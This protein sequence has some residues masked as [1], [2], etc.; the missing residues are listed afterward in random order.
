MLTAISNVNLNQKYS[1]KPSFG[2]VVLSRV[3]LRTV[4]KNGDIFYTPILNNEKGIKG[5]YQALSRRVNSAKN[6]TLLTKLSDAIADFK[7]NKPIIYSTIINVRSS[8]K[9]FL[10][11]GSDAKMA[12]DMG[13]DLIGA[14][15]NRRAYANTIK[16]EILNKPKKR[17]FNPDGDEIG[18]DLIVEGPKGKR[19]LVDIE[20][21]TLQ[22][23]SKAKPPK[24]A[25]NKK[26]IAKLNE[27]NIK[28]QNTSQPS[29]T[30]DEIQ[31]EFDFVSEL[32][33]KKI[34]PRDYD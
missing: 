17:V 28:P 34:N 8:F 15:N 11:T 23:I 16:E 10:L 1:Y 22:E 26:E 31:R 14:M 18:I 19:K 25:S 12:R 29:T 33:P 21:S 2:S 3:L 32:K 4:D 5:I 27:V 6:N 30:P 7:I 13:T 24:F 20:I 9:R